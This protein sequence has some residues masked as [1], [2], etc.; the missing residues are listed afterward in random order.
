[1]REAA[2]DLLGEG[3]Q[4]IILMETTWGFGNWAPMEEPQSEGL[5]L[6]SLLVTLA[7]P[8]PISIALPEPEWN[9]QSWCLD[10]QGRQEAHR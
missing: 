4:L 10:I 8:S 2:G 3:I 9:T 5:G 1:M 6:P 7:P